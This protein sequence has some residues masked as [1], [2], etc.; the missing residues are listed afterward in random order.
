[1]REEEAGGIREALARAVDWEDA[2]AG[3]ESSVD[4]MPF[5]LLGRAPAGFGHSVW[6]LAEHVRLAQR[7]ILDFCRD[8]EYRERA[9]PDDYWP[10]HAAPPDE[11]SWARCLEAVRDDRASLAHLVRDS[12]RSL[13]AEIPHGQGQTILREVLLVIDHTAYHVGQIVAVR[14]ALGAWPG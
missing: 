11:T 6:Q 4:G 8:P 5:E 2:H 9:W 3:F 10:P 13:V 14:K 1:M 7:D 12:T